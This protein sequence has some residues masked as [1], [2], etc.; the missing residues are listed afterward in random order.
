MSDVPVS[1]L[2]AAV[3]LVNARV[4]QQL[5]KGVYPTRGAIR[6]AGKNIM[7]RAVQLTASHSL[8]IS[9][10]LQHPVSVT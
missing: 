1:R 10:N 5:A 8:A 3:F 6:F 9:I 7:H 4:V 2:T